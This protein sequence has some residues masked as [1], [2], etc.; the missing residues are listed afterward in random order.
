MNKTN[1]QQL[2]IEVEALQMRKQSPNPQ[3]KLKLIHLN[4]FAQEFSNLVPCFKQNI[5]LPSAF[6][7]VC[8]EPVPVSHKS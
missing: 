3:E 7:D 8:T 4:I 6:Q 1:F 5:K 2:D